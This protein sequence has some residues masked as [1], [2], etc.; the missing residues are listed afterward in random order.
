M[1]Y[2]HDEDDN[3][4]APHI[5]PA[6]MPSPHSKFAPCFSGCTDTLEDFLEEFEGLAYDWTLMDLQRVEVII[7]YVDLSLRDFWRSLSGYR[8]RDWPLFWHSLINVFGSIIPRPQVMRQRLMC[9]VHDSSRTQMN[10]TDDVIQYYRQFLC[11]GE[12]LVH[13]GHLTEEDRNAVFWY[14]YHPE[15]REVLR[16]RLISKNPF[17]PPDVPFHFEHVLGCARAAFAYDGTFPTWSQELKFGPSS[18]YEQPVAR[19]GS[20]DTYGLREMLRAVTSNTETTSILDKLPLPPQS[21]PQ[22]QF[23]SSSPSV[24]ESQHGLVHLVTLDQPKPAYTLSTTLLP[25]ASPSPTHTHLLTPSTAADEIPGILSTFPSPS[26]MPAPFSILTSDFEY[27]PSAT[28]DQ[29]EHAPMLSSMPPFP[30]PFSSTFL[31]SPTCLAMEDQPEPESTSMPSIT[32]SSPALPLTS[33][34]APL[35]IDDLDDPEFESAPLSSSPTSST[36]LHSVTEEQ[37]EPDPEPLPLIAP[38]STFASTSLPSSSSTLLLSAPFPTLSHTHSLTPSATADVPDISSTLTSVPTLALSI[39]NDVPKI[40]SVPHSSSSILPMNFEC[41]SSAM[42]DQPEFEPKH[43]TLSLI[44]PASPSLRT[45]SLTPESSKNIPEFSSPF[46]TSQFVSL[47]SS[48]PPAL[49]PD[50]SSS[51]SRSSSQLSRSSESRSSRSSLCE[52]GLLPALNIPISPHSMPP[53]RPPGL[54]TIASVSTLLKVAPAPASPTFPPIPQQVTTAQWLLYL[55]LQQL[56]FQAPSLIYEEA[57]STLAAPHFSHPLPLLQS[58][59]PSSVR[60]IFTFTLITTTALVLAL[61]NFS[62]TISTH[63]CEFR[64]KQDISN[65]RISTFKTSKSSN[66]VAHRLQLGQYAPRAPRLVFDPRGQPSSSSFK[67]PSAHEDI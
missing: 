15:D 61:F 6:A 53:Q 64:S 45:P 31:P 49:L 38:A 55:V 56:E 7:C 22:P 23:P 63:M 13:S 21:T 14:G 19:L 25:S 60:S 39:I 46:P 26:T 10:C 29:P 24:L 9:Y 2:D 58:S 5:G 33:S 51:L 59:S 12:P 62:A 18:R 67:L 44:T 65:N 4:Y 43:A 66:T 17:Q 28:V 41:P 27:L 48:M 36:C 40:A 32:P 50:Q 42:V 3:P 54:K 52:S 37:P 11:L 20:R 30:P 16:P 34:L 1:Y 8:S 47:A 35:S 57:L